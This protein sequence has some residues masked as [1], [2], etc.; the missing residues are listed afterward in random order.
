MGLPVPGKLAG[1]YQDSLR[2]LRDW[3]RWRRAR[4]SPAPRPSLAGRAAVALAPGAGL[5]ARL[6]LLGAGADGRVCGRPGIVPAAGPAVPFGHGLRDAASPGRLGASGVRAIPVLGTIWV[7]TWRIAHPRHRPRPRR[8]RLR[9][10]TRLFTLP[11][12]R[13]APVIIAERC[14]GRATLLATPSFPA[15]PGTT[16]TSSRDTVPCRHDLRV[17][18]RG[19]GCSARPEDT[20]AASAMGGRRLAESWFSPPSLAALASITTTRPA[21]HPESD[22]PMASWPRGPAES[23]GRRRRRDL[24]ACAGARGRH[25]RP[26]SLEP[27]VWRLRCSVPWS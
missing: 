17:S 18:G 26:V 9:G 12:A 13:R 10:S 23:R 20:D 1:K 16:T 22:P 15:P 11:S 8:A 5:L 14:H 7:A 19:W 21:P 27:G 24:L 6:R 4:Q 25:G 3:R 2:G